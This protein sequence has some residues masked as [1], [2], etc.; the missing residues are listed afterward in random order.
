MY[1]HTFKVGCALKGEDFYLIQQELRKKGPNKWVALKEGM[2]YWGLSDK[3][4]II[5]MKRTKK[6]DFFSYSIIYKISALRVIEN[7][8]FVGLFDTQNYEELEDKVNSILNKACKLLPCLEKCTL[9]RIDFCVNTEFDDHK[10]VEA[11]IK[12]VK[13]GNIPPKLKLYERNDPKAK[14]KKASKNEF[15]VRAGKYVEVSIYNKY[16]EMKEQMDY[17]Y[18]D[19]EIERAKNIVRIEIRCKEGK[20]RELAKKYHISSIERFMERADGIGD[21]LYQYYLGKM[22]NR[23]SVCTLKEA[24]ERIDMSEYRRDTIKKLKEFLSK[25]NECRSAA[26]AFEYYKKTDMGY[27]IKLLN[28]IETNYVTVT[29]DVRQI[30]GDYIPTPLELYKAFA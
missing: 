22:F 8:N 1:I 3:G 7:D 24:L 28:N 25:C 6:K 10:Q 16:A 23:G 27:I 12:T 15:T 20:V 18:P 30:L 26:K 11:Y 19:G 21:E 14:R 9:S 17:N 13:R 4:I 5:I 2:R 29:K